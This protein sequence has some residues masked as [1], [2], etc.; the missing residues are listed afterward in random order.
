V[1]TFGSA[2]MVP[3]GGFRSVIN[4]VSVRDGVCYLD[5]WR[6]AMAALGIQK[7]VIFI[8]NMR[9]GAPLVDHSLCNYWQ[10]WRSN[11]LDNYY[12]DLDKRGLR[13]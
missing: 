10:F 5:P 12:R 6:Y 2:T 13:V 4:I 8:G 7:N 9:D 3:E 11:Y 1:V